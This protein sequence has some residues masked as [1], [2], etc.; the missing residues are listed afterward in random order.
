M[1]EKNFR[2]TNIKN[3]LQEKL[4]SLRF[5]VRL[6]DSWNQLPESVR[7]EEMLPPSRGSLKD[8]QHELPVCSRHNAKKWKRR[9]EKVI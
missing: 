4:V 3:F 5:V 2:S 7:A 6:V 9:I 1:S 8:W